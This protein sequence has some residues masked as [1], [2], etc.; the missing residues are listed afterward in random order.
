MNF[1]SELVDLLKN[2]KGLTS[3]NKA[4]DAIPGMNSGNLSKIRKGLENRFLNDEQALYIANECGLNP[5][6]VLVNLAAERTKSEDA[7]SAWANIAKKLSR[8]VTA[9]ALAVSLVFCGVQ[10][11]DSTKA[12]FA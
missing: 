6:W 11:K 5:E 1:S 10:H 8:T 7:K 12:V 4:A 2:K 3:D 9:A